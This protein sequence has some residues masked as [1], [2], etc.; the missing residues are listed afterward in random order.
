MISYD[1][2]RELQKYQSGPDS[3]ILSLYVNVD[4]SNAANL[5]RGFETKIESLFREVAESQD[6]DE[7]ARQGFEAECRR[8][9]RF[10]G[11]YTPKG[12]ALVVFSDSHRDFWWQRDLQVEIPSGLR[13]SAKPW[14]RPLLEVIEDL[15]RFGVVLMDKHRA[16]IF[17]VDA[18]GVE[19]QAEILSEVP[20]KH[21]TTGTDHIWSQTQMDRDHDKHVQWHAKR[22][23]DELGSIIERT[24]L[25][26]MVVGGPV[27][28]TSVF[29]TSLPKRVQQMIVG[30]ISTP[31]DASHERL[32]AELKDVRE[33]TEHEDE[34]RIIDTVV[35]AAM[36]AD[37]AVLGVTDTLAAIQEGRVYR[38]V[39]ARDF[40]VEGKECG[41]CHVLVANGD[42][43]CLF[44]GGNLE[45]APDLINRAAHRVLDMG[46][47]VQHVSGEAAAKLGDAG[48]G[49]VLRF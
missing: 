29:A 17:V 31:V 24:K 28:A 45:A 1:D 4:Q 23:A 16:R 27:E 47:K 8:V 40:R 36:K 32:L 34:S 13:F 18:G 25:S 20:G 2:I 19:Q 5:N 9:R 48:V 26:R 35:T 37:R 44:C 10:L 42:E 14:V 21:V 49:A 46:G 12:K 6:S 7:A 41:A 33:R 39:V 15:G 30:T 11:E 3:H 38:M 22:V 43:Q